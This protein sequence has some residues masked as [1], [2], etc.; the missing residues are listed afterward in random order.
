VPA[1]DDLLYS[2]GYVHLEKYIR[3]GRDLKQKPGTKPM[4]KQPGNFTD[5]A[6][7]ADEIK[8]QVFP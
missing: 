2:F 6:A 3:N 5:R 7:A 8:G 4:E 1:A